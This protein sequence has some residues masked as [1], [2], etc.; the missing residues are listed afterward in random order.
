MRGYRRRPTAVW[1]RIV[2][3]CHY[4]D[5]DEARGMKRRQ[6]GGLIKKF[7]IVTSRRCSLHTFRGAAASALWL[8]SIATAPESRAKRARVCT[9]SR[10]LSGDM[11]PGLGRPF[12]RG[13]LRAPHSACTKVEKRTSGRDVFQV[14]RMALA[15]TMW[16]QGISDRWATKVGLLHAAFHRTP[17]LVRRQRSSLK[18]WNMARWGDKMLLVTL[19]NPIG[20]ISLAHNGTEVLASRALES[21]MRTLQRT[22]EAVQE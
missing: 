20:H 7:T 13:R 17:P 15:E 11:I 19:A 3:A 14:T 22:G 1:R 16:K 10:E 8:S 2:S 6:E 12:G 9:K 4:R 21:N 18:C 5:G